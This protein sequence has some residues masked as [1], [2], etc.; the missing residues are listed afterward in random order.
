MQWKEMHQTLEI[1]HSTLKK[2][3]KLDQKT[4]FLADFD[5]FFVYAIL[6]P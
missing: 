6:R 4:D 1:F 2:K 5:R 3:S